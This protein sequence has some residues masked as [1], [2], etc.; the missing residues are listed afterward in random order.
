MPGICHTW[1]PAQCCSQHVVLRPLVMLGA[2]ASHSAPVLEQSRHD[3][4]LRAGAPAYA[5]LRAKSCGILDWR[6][7]AQGASG[8]FLL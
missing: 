5:A 4:S 6:R 8:S 1:S 3:I 2:E 7:F